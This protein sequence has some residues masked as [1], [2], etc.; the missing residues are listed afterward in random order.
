MS[1][2][3]VSQLLFIVVMGV[4]LL[5][6]VPVFEAR[7]GKSLT[8]LLFGFRRKSDR[9]KGQTTVKGK[10]PRINNGT[11]GELLAFVSQLIR[12][13]GKNGMQV[14]APGTVTWKGK[15]TRLSALLVTPSGITGIYCL[16]FGGRITGVKEP[17]SWR[18]HIN[19]ED[20]TFPNPLTACREQ[21]ELLREAMADA[22]IH[23]DV[24][25][26]TVFTNPR[27]TLCEVPSSRIYSQSGFMEHL[28]ETSALRNG[29]LEVKETAQKLAVLADVKGKKEEAKNRKKEAKSQKK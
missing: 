20:K 18:Q 2:I 9:T 23:G 27:A 25:V 16:G 14:V 19:G 24:D 10:E 22:G 28:R 3:P 26:I 7:T 1:E 4:L 11:K 8:E 12:F 13:A 6:I 5:L 15:T 17:A 29:N 21:E